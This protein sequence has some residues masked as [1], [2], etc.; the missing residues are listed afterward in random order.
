MTEKKEW[1][2]IPTKS[3]I[4]KAEK[5]G[6]TLEGTYIK[7]EPKPFKGR[8]NWKYCFE[9]DH[10]VNV[11]G[12][13]SF[14]GTD[15]LNNAL[16]DI[17]LGYDV[18]I[19][20]KKTLMSADP[21]KNGFKVFEV[22]VKMSKDDPLYKKLYPYEETSNPGAEMNLKDDNDA[23][24]LINNYTE[25]YEADH[26]GQKP[27]AENLIKMAETD[28]DINNTMK[29]RVKAEVASQVK[30]GKI[31]SKGGKINGK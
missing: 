4:W 11:D 29:S 13:V 30:A 17:P 20:Y 24:K 5:Q 3:G 31:K 23:K 16:N 28:P 9:S 6:D 25:L 14:Y 2:R 19:V 8:P 10:E 1:I 26:H 18:K 7:R 27:I 21:K 12:K 22:F 15:G